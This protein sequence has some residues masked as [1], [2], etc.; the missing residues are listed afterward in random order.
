MLNDIEPEAASTGHF[1]HQSA[2]AGLVGDGEGWFVSVGCEVLVSL[3][4]GDSV[5]D[6]AEEDGKSGGCGEEEM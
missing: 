1:V 4:G 3:A 2:N 5:P 6:S